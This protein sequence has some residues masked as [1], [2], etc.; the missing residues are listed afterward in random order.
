MTPRRDAPGRAVT[1]IITSSVDTRIQ[2]ESGAGGFAPG[3]T[4]TRESACARR[5]E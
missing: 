1:S 3:L 2:G 5:S 4:R